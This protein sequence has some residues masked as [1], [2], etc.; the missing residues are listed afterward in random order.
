MEPK[1][2]VIVPVYRVEP[3]LE[4]C[5]ASLQE[6]TLKELEIILV[7]DGSPDNCPAICDRLAAEDARIKVI[8]KENEGAG[9]SRNAGLEAAAGEYVGFVDSDDFVEPEMFETLWRAAHKWDADM[10][11][12]GELNFERG[13]QGEKKHCFARIE[14]FEGPDGVKKLLLGTAGALPGERED[15]RYGFAVWKNLY[16]LELFRDG[17]PRFLSERAVM[18]EDMLF[19]LEVI[20]RVQ[21][22]VG[23]PGAFYHYCNNGDSFSK[24]FREGRLEQA[25]IL[26]SAMERRL[27]KA[28][29]EAE[30]RL[31]LDRQFQAYTRRISLKEIAHAR[32]CGMGE[33]EL[34]ER[35]RKICGD[36]KVSAVLRRYPWYR[37]PV[38]QAAFAFAMRYRLIW[39]QRLLVELRM[40]K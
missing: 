13:E 6:Q 28:A 10:A 15:S 4:R 31:Y 20:P 34:N 25:K 23:V 36:P 40:K 27:S 30:Y 1:V 9:L 38:K 11:L 16:R 33:K 26:M 37:L 32:Q 24:S 12:S 14:V 2:S 39:L 35:L 17:G 8:H 18:S 19:L 3:Y 29:P 21:R 22:A 5:V 7:D